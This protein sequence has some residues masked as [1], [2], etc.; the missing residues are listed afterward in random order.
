MDSQAQ[1][2]PIEVIQKEDGTFV[3]VVSYNKRISPIDVS[4]IQV[5]GKTS[6]ASRKEAIA[7]GERYIAEQKA[8]G[9]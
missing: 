6:F 5:K 3:W 9:N 4:F 1:W 7:D 2:E 8:K